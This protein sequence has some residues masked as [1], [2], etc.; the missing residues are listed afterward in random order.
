[1]KAK[2]A[3]LCEPDYLPKM[4]AGAEDFYARRV[5]P[6]SGDRHL[7]VAEIDGTWPRYMRERRGP[8]SWYWPGDA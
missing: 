6:G 1:M 8:K 5:N 4:L 3:T 2:A 7:Q